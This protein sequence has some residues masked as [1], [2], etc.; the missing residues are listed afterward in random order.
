MILVQHHCSQSTKRS[1]VLL[2]GT[3]LIGSSIL[4]GLRQS[5]ETTCHECPFSWNEANQ[6]TR[7]AEGIYSRLIGTV[8]SD[9]NCGG[10][11]NSIALVWSAGKAGFFASQED[12]DRELESYH[13]VLSLLEKLSLRFP[14]IK[15]ECHLLSSAGGLF[16]DQGLVDIS[17]QPSPKRLYGHLKYE[18]ENLLAKLDSDIAKY[19]YRPTSVYGYSGP[20]K[21]MGLI[22]TLISN[23]IQNQTSTIVGSLNTLRDYVFNDDIGNHIAAQICSEERM[24]ETD[25]R[26]LASGKPSSIFEIQHFVER[27]IRKKVLLNFLASPETDNATD[28]VVGSDVLTENWNPIDVST[29]VRCVKDLFMAN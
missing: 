2:F 9:G 29:G 20:G 13:V 25:I 7:D 14:T 10:A 12:I 6:R 22:P 24:T 1:V 11:P 5:G 15:V 19:I 16:E 18:Q 28:I 23:G 17:T 8:E 3:G 21:R 27:V 4:K 26:L